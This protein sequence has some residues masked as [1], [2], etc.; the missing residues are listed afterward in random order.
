MTERGQIHVP[1][2]TPFRYFLHI[3]QLEVALVSSA[4]RELQRGRLELP[5]F[6]YSRRSMEGLDPPYSH[7]QIHPPPALTVHVPRY[8]RRA[9]AH[10]ISHA[11]RLVLMAL[12][13]YTPRHTDG[14]TYFSRL[15][16]RR[17]GGTRG[18]ISEV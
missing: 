4:A 16:S 17:A 15:L 10:A 2:S 6:Y 3:R 5:L 13:T 1:D 12:L 11:I 9:A 7:I 14:C 18:R 8:S